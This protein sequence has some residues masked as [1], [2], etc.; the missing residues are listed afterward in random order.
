LFE[1]K[2][3]IIY[4]LSP[5]NFC[6]FLGEFW[7]EKC[8]KIIFECYEQYFVIFSLLFSLCKSYTRRN[9]SSKL[10]YGKLATYFN[11][12]GKSGVPNPVTCKERK[13]K[14]KKKG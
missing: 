14:R 5:R 13:E 11:N 7:P 1:T 10:F 12:L 2:A 3:K 9:E 4:L 8:G 6:I